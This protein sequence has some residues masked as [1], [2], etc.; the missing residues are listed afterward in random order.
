M[1][2]YHHHHAS[3]SIRAAAAQHSQQYYS[4]AATAT[5][6]AAEAAAVAVAASFAVVHAKN[7]GSSDSSDLRSCSAVKSRPRSWVGNR[8]ACLRLLL[9]HVLN[10]V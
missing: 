1:R 8:V 6:T 3:K 5:A 4:A 7:D 2:R 10:R 9:L